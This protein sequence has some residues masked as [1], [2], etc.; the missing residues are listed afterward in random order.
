MNNLNDVSNRI[1]K[2]CNTL[3][4]TP[5]GCV[6]YNADGTYDG[7]AIAQTSNQELS[8]Y[9]PINTD[10]YTGSFRWFDGNYTEGWDRN[11]IM[12]LNPNGLITKGDVTGFANLSDKKFKE[13]IIEYNGW[14]EAL[15]K[16]RPVTFTWND[17][18]PQGEK[19]GSAD[20]GLIAQD[21]A[22]VYPYAHDVKEMN[23]ESV[24]IVRY[25]KIVP[26][27]LAVVKDQ[28]KRL[29]ELETKITAAG[30]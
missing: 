27:L 8:F 17:Q 28:Q 12:T 26:L 16:L 20:I 30:I 9:A 2:I 1:A 4:G 18:V 13:N 5:Y 24:H 23:G 22:E 14:K 21:V 25:E 6:F 19:A 15:E 29:D 3:K 10:D 7:G 11:I